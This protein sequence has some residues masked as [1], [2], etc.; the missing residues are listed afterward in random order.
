[1]QNEL[2]SGFAPP[3]FHSIYQKDNHCPLN[4]NC[5]KDFEEGIAYAK[6]VNKPVLLDFTGWACVNCR[7][8]E[9]NIWSQPNIYSLIN[10]DYVLISLYVDD[11]QRTLPEEEQFDF[12]K[13]NGKVKRI[14]TYGDKWATLQ[15]ANFKTASQPF[16]V[17][18]SPE[19][20]VLNSPQQYTDHATYYN[21]LKTGLDRFN[22]N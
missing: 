9:E 12:I 15:A 18:M 3:K 21:W 4:L 13:S 10:D 2:L 7:K 16:Y 5:F 14:R 20:E 1:M 17:L 22:S 19:L 8:M 11:H 6:S